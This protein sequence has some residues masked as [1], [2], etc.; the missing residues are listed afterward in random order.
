ML[1]DLVGVTK[2]ELDDFFD[3]PEDHFI[4]TSGIWRHKEQY[5]RKSVSV[6][7]DKYFDE[8]VKTY[9]RTK[10][11]V[12]G[13]F[14]RKT[15]HDLLISHKAS[16]YALTADIWHYFGSIS[17]GH[18][19]TTIDTEASLAP[20]AN[21]L[22]KI[23]FFNQSLRKGLIASPA[24]SELVGLNIDRLVAR[25]QHENNLSSVV[26]SRYYD[27]LIFSGIDRGQLELMRNVLSQSLQ[28]ELTLELNIKKSKIKL[29]Q[30]TTILG[31]AFDKGEITISKKFKNK[32]R[33]TENLYKSLSEEFLSEVYTK[34]RSVG[35]IIG[36]LHR[37]IDN[38]PP[39]AKYE[40]ALSS[41]Y[42]ELE[43]LQTLRDEYKEDP[44]RNDV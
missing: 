35:T 44:Y 6:V 37:I 4:L 3:V 18:I 5:H 17:Y 11:P 19:K 36:S 13:A 2:K 30:G 29:L 43:R 22:E 40:T 24:I 23:Y 15:I 33:A 34:L 16:K 21:L 10:R 42:Q 1:N 26:Y 32:L 27:D 9:L 14:A 20:Y 7:T 25:L 39:T 41:Y 38:S 28:D 12:N 8:L 31:L